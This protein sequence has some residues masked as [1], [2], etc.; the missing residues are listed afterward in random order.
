MAAREESIPSTWPMHCL[1]L[2]FMWVGTL[3]CKPVLPCLLQASALCQSQSSGVHIKNTLCLSQDGSQEEL[4]PC[5]ASMLRALGQEVLRELWLLK[6][7]LLW[8]YSWRGPRQKKAWKGSFDSAVPSWESPS[9]RPKGGAP[10][11]ILTRLGHAPL[12]HFCTYHSNRSPCLLIHST[13]LEHKFSHATLCL[14]PS[15]AP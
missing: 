7:L 2:G 6:G 12:P 8:S 13:I 5:S 11:F 3:A 4:S 1:S 9:P 14:N 10:P 15:V